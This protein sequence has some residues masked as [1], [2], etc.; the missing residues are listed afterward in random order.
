MSGRKGKKGKIQRLA[1]EARAYVEQLLD[2][3]RWTLDEVFEL[4]KRR[5]PD[6]DFSRS[7]L[8]RYQPEYTQMRERMREIE[9]VSNALVGGLGEG[10]A[11]KANRLLAQ[12]VTTA[13]T[14]AALKLQS[15]D[16]DGDDAVSMS[17]LKDLSLAAGRAMKAQRLAT[18]EALAI[19]QEAR[20]AL[21]REQA[22]RLDKVVKESGLTDDVAATF[23]RK[24]LGLK[25]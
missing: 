8:H 21:Q 25:A 18:E 6:A 10:G 12:A 11:E 2:E 19:A 24:V 9:R 4:V 17:E 22:A 13:V 1:P 15:R 7:G 20:N 16:D 3:D 23:R 5:F 14:H